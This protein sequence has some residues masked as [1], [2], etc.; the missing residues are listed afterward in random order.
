MAKDSGG[1]SWSA[2]WD[3]VFGFVVRAETEEQARSLVVGCGGNEE[4]SN[5]WTDPLQSD[6]TVLTGDGEAMVIMRDF[7]AG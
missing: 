5:P 3:A 7:D 1:S 6:C 4:M 2:Y